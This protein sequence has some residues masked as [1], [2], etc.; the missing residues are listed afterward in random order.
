MDDAVLLTPEQIGLI[1][2]KIDSGRYASTSDVVGKALRLLERADAMEAER[3]NELRQAWRA[4]QDSGDAGTLDFA[5]LRE[6]A[7]QKLA[8]I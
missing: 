4:G 3:V 6:A 2:A 1:K 8:S 7:R 5:E